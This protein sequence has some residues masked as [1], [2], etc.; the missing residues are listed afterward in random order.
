[1]K[2]PVKEILEYTLSH[3]ELTTREAVFSYFSEIIWSVE[4][5][6][7]DRMTHDQRV[8]FIEFMEICRQKRK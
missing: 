4:K 7:W 6:E 8:Q 5:D 2:A 1:M 3:P